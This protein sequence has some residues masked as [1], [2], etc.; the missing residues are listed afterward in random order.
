MGAL[1]D[2]DA[3]WELEFADLALILI[4][5]QVEQIEIKLLYDVVASIVDSL[6]VVGLIEE[7][8]LRADQ[9]D[10]ETRRLEG[11]LLVHEDSSTH[12]LARNKSVVAALKLDSDFSTFEE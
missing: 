1:R 2:L 10:L 11:V 6:L 12:L 9:R 8:V 5:C 4:L 3:E 7:C